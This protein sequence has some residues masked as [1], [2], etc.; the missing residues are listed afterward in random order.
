MCILAIFTALGATWFNYAESYLA[1]TYR[2]QADILVVEG[3]IGRRGVCAAAEE[4]RRGGYRLIVC[5]GGLTSGRWEDKPVSYAEMA[6]GE[7]I[8]LG[9]PQ[10]NILVA[11]AEITER[12]RTFECA[13][14]VRRTLRE[15]GIRPRGSMYLRS[16]RTPEEV[17]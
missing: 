16:A 11:N 17:V 13:V 12:Q 1:L 15:A 4:F 14:A 9:V 3:W 10:A 6:A 7:M 2:S 8:R 5:T